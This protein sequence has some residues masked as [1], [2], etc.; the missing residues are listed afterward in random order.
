M[1]LKWANVGACLAIALMC[2]VGMPMGPVSAHG[3]GP[4][5]PAAP[6]VP[7]VSTPVGGALFGPSIGTECA[8]STSCQ[9][10]LA[11]VSGDD[12]LIQANTGTILPTAIHVAGATATL[13]SSYTGNSPY[14]GLY[15]AL[16][17]HVGADMIY[18]NNSAAKNTCFTAVAVGGLAASPVDALGNSTT[19]LGPTSEF[20][21][22]TGTATRA[23]EIQILG[24]TTLSY[25]G[26]EH[27][28]TLAGSGSAVVSQSPQAFVGSAYWTNS[29]VAKSVPASGSN[30]IA[31][32]ASIAVYHRYES[33]ILFTGPPKVPTG[34]MVTATTGASISYAWTA[35]PG[36]VLNYTL[37]WSAACSGS[38][39][40]VSI[41]NYT[42]YGLSGL[43]QSQTVC[44]KVEAW[45][46]TGASGFGISATATTGHVPVAPTSL[47]TTA[48]AISSIA[49]AWTA[50]HGTVLN[51]TLVWSAACTGT[52]HR[53]SAGA[54]TTY[55]LTGLAPHQTVCAKV[56]A[57]NATGESALSTSATAT[58]TH[59]PAAPTL[60]HTTAIGWTSI[61]YAWTPPAGTVVNYTF[62]WVNASSCTGHF[63]R[64]SVG[65][66]HAYTLTGLGPN[67]VVCAT[68]SAWNATGQSAVSLTWVAATEPTGGGGVSGAGFTSAVGP[69]LLGALTVGV[70]ALVGMGLWNAGWF[71]RRP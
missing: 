69:I 7:L 71:R 68:V 16:A 17:P 56:A 60:L 59:V 63:T 65:T 51:Y 45:N 28:F 54:G 58:T 24:D 3:P 38:Y 14:S 21:S 55:T 43:S 50:P 48:V 9:E 32:I 26:N 1:E 18:V 47:H 11:V 2:L 61:A 5:G 67:T 15:L 35:S 31:D 20:A 22:S 29:I 25:Y 57:W 12:V 62:E 66:G 39:H 33:A 36:T 41:G 6:V 53:T 44:A 10:P 70:V 4:P 34:L 64:I 40:Y 30:T 49:Y 42:T 19:G 8:S 37:Q 23:G 27:P 46:A 13:V 52:Q